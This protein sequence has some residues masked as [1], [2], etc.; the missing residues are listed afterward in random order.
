MM[1]VSDMQLS[2]YMCVCQHTHRK[3]N[4]ETKREKYFFSSIY[5]RGE[6]NNPQALS[7]IIRNEFR[8]LHTQKTPCDQTFR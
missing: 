1:L 3:N 4:K 7:I 2:F 6:K 5:K 8:D